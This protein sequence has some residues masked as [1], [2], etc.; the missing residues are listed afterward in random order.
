MHLAGHGPGPAELT[1]RIGS[2]PLVLASLAISASN[3]SQSTADEAIIATM[4]ASFSYDC[5]LHSVH[6]CAFE[7]VSLFT[8]KERDTESGNDYF[9][10]RYYAS[11]P[12]G[13]LAQS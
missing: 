13:A 7:Q 5:T 8:G 9:G 6:L 12:D 11:L 2:S 10:A 3:K 1:T 4:Q